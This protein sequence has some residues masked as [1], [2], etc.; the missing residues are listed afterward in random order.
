MNLREFVNNGQTTYSQIKQDLF[1]LYYYQ[2]T[3]GFFVEFGALDG[4]DTSNTYLLET[5]HDW[6]GI[7]AEPLPRFKEALQTNRTASL[8]FRCVSSASGE[9]IQFGEVE[10]FPALS[11]AVKLKDQDSVWKQRRQNPKIHDVTTVTLDDLLDEH[12]APERID[13]LSIDTEGAEYEILS[14]YS[15]KRNFN[16]M[17]VE[18]T[19]AAEEEKLKKLLFA[20]DYMI[21]H[22]DVSTWENW[23]A[24]RPWYETLPKTN[25]SH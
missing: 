3:P 19:N 9:T 16:L 14:N 10:D 2:D 8:D 15:F 7:L 25:A 24:Y 4:V 18:H 11:T 21:V 5:E 22:K 13:Y 20:M 1:V 23:Y 6:K 12:N 17:T